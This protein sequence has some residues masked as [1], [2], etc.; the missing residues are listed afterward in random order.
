MPEM[1]DIFLDAN[2]EVEAAEPEQVEMSD[3]E[4]EEIYATA[5]A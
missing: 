5:G 1:Q 4:Y 2:S 3:E